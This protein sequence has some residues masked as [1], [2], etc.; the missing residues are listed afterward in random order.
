MRAP[1]YAADCT[2]SP[3]K[4]IVFLLAL[5]AAIFLS[6]KTARTE[7]VPDTV[8]FGDALKEAAKSGLEKLQ[9]S[10]YGPG[11][12]AGPDRT[13]F[14][15]PPENPEQKRLLDHI[16]ELLT[17]QG[18]VII[19][20]SLIAR[21]VHDNLLDGDLPSLDE[22]LE[23]KPILWGGV[24]WA[25]W[26]PGHCEVEINLRL[27][28][29]NSSRDS[30]S[31]ELVTCKSI[32]E[33]GSSG[34]EAPEMERAETTSSKAMDSSNSLDNKILLVVS[35]CVFAVLIILL[36]IMKKK[37]LV[38][39]LFLV[40]LL[41]VGIWI[42]L[43][44]THPET[45]TSRNKHKQS[46]LTFNFAP[47]II[48]PLEN[49][50]FPEN[51]FGKPGYIGINEVFSVRAVGDDPE[52]GSFS[53]CRHGKTPGWINVDRESG[54]VSCESKASSAEIPTREPGLT[55][56]S[57]KIEDEDGKSTIRTFS[58]RV[59]NPPEFEPSPRAVFEIFDNQ[60]F[61]TEITC[62][63]ADNHTVE[64]T[65]GKKFPS[66]A[67]LVEKSKKAGRS[68]YLLE[69]VP[70]KGKPGNR[71]VSL[72]ASD[73]IDQT[74]IS[75]TVS[76]QLSNRP[77]KLQAGHP[78]TYTPGRVYEE[79]VKA[80]DPEGDPITYRLKKG[81]TGMQI[82]PTRGTVTWPVTGK[83]TG[84]VSVE[85]EISDGSHDVTEMFLLTPT[86]GHDIRIAMDVKTIV[87]SRPSSDNQ[88]V[89]LLTN[90][91]TEHDIILCPAKGTLYRISGRASLTGLKPFSLYK[92]EFFTYES[93]SLTLR[94]VT[95]EGQELR[96]FS[97]TGVERANGSTPEAARTMCLEHLIGKIK[98]PLIKSVQE[99][100]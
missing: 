87:D 43:S 24:T 71:Q 99:Q 63:D 5:T 50:I 95:R 1:S 2:L 94:L 59:N 19:D 4:R 8:H 44:G 78:S 70:E 14:L 16:I 9:T 12:E 18:Y 60:P 84:E 46:R 41:G 40:L 22:Q 32:V 37:R 53:F 65:P 61:E 96:T 25:R 27:M 69:F 77:P 15:L 7:T 85:V 20:H 28:K 52:K 21:K 47:V 35:S 80:V 13:I 17:R 23:G 6:I 3:C 88:A 73:T 29:L 83:T 74:E 76:V 81:P 49:Q 39:V 68:T 42:I 48:W 92:M 82:D 75:F 79:Q 90:V 45:D 55:R 93:G 66:N 98:A 89:S 51:P 91:L 72:T 64:I 58:I 38:I 31:K 26:S 97:A 56:V 11:I 57:V 34:T 100:F 36:A 10:V 33:K 62:I 54:V 86:P 67:N 30:G